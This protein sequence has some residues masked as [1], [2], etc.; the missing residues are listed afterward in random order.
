[1]EK[2]DLEVLRAMLGPSFLDIRC[3]LKLE[4]ITHMVYTR[5]TVE[6]VR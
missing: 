2:Q 4:C 1:M 6:Y 5:N 3:E